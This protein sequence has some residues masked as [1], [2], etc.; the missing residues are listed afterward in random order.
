VVEKVDRIS[1]SGGLDS[2]L[3]DL[4]RIGEPRAGGAATHKT[5]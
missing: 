3:S 4:V 5:E 1:V 2:L